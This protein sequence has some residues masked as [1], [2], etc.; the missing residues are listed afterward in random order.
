MRYNLE[1]TNVC[2]SLMLNLP[3]HIQRTLTGL[4]H[5]C[6]EDVHLPICVANISK[7]GIVSI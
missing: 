4:I 3:D 7:L 1:M 6:L 2:I 5:I